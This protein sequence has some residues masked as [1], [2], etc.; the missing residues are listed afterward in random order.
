MTGAGSAQ[1][2]PTMEEILASIRRIISEDADDGKAGEDTDEMD[3]ADD[4]EADASEDMPADDVLELTEAIAEPEEP[5]PEPEPVQDDELMIFEQQD[6]PE[7]DSA[8]P[9]PAPR[10]VAR[11]PEPHIVSDDVAQLTAA[12]F[13]K[14]SRDLPIAIGESRTV[15]ALVEDLLRP[16]LKDW[17]DTHLPD[18]VE[19]LV[20]EEIERVSRQRMRR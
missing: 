3:V 16:M 13:G 7:P 15:E 4:G 18:I 20:E 11:D 5:E 19:R 12:A 17:L 8:P 9:P 10:P 14:L 1:P 2:E 6:E